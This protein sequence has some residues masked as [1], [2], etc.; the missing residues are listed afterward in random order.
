R[1]IR[2]FS[3]ICHKQP[4][5]KRQYTPVEEDSLTLSIE[6]VNI[7]KHGFW[8]THT[9][10]Y[11][12][13]LPDMFRLVPQR[14]KIGYPSLQFESNSEEKDDED[15]VVDPKDFAICQL[16]AQGKS[17]PEVASRIGLSYGATYNRGKKLGLTG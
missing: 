1:I 7:S 9:I 6:Q 12:P 2:K 4:E 13:G 10:R 14:E 11:F 16:R 17:W 5:N 8:M 15:M 3:Y